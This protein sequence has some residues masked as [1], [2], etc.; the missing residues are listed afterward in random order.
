MVLPRRRSRPRP[1]KQH[2]FL[3]AVLAI[4]IVVYLVYFRP[5]PRRVIPPAPALPVPD[6]S[7][8]RLQVPK[9][10]D[11]S[12]DFDAEYEALLGAVPE[13]RGGR[14]ARIAFLIMA[15]G[16]DDVQLLKRSLPWLYSPLNFFL[17]SDGRACSRSCM[18]WTAASHCCLR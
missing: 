7:L 12:R 11:S 16:A 14:R 3:L 10:R 13:L 2:G 18:A 15:H 8:G 6:L 17:V 1:K 5:A 4:G 9:W